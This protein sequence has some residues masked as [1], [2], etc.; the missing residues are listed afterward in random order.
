ETERALTEIWAEVLGV[1]QI[2]IH[3]DFFQL[4]GHSLRAAQVIT[5][6][7]EVLGVK[8]PLQAMFDS[9]TVAGLARIIGTE[10]PTWEAETIKPLPRGDSTLDELLTELDQLSTAEAR[11]LLGEQ[12]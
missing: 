6:V 9:P 5:R 12:L 4:G 3:D 11:R 8:L 1:D 2:G 10:A 7:T